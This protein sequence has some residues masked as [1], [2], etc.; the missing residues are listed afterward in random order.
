MAAG[1]ILNAT[2]VN[3]RF[4]KPLD[5][6]MVTAMAE[7]HELLVTVEENALQGGAGSAV[8]QQLLSRDCRVRIINLGIPDAFIGHGD[9]AQQ[10][11]DCGLDTDGIVAAARAA[12]GDAVPPA[13]THA[14]QP[15][16]HLNG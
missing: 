6:D 9:H 12:A 11:A 1:E 14:L 3:M 8:N 10:L 4:I 16:K 7:T 13:G 15:G 2:V 5:N